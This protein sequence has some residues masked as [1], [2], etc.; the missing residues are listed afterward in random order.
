MVLDS[1]L[2]GE[3]DNRQQLTASTFTCFTRFYVRFIQT[4]ALILKRVKKIEKCNGKK[5][6][7]YVIIM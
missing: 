1:K 6:Q 4:I 5:Y 3:K 2:Q 7:Y